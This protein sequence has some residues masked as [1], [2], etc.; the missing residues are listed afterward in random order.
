MILIKSPT[1]SPGSRH[2]VFIKTVTPKN[3][4]YRWQTISKKKPSG[5]SNFN[6]IL[7]YSKNSKALKK[8]INILQKKFITKQWG[9]FINFLHYFNNKTY[10]GL[11]KYANGSYANIALTHGMLPGDII[12]CTNMRISRF[13]RYNLGDTVLL[14]WLNRRHVFYNVFLFHKSKVIFAK[15]AGTFCS[16]VSNDTEKNYAK[17]KLP[18]GDNKVI[19]NQTFVTLGRNSNILQNSVVFGKAG[20]VR[21]N[22]FKSSVRGVAMNPVDHPHGGRTK[23]NS[24]EK[25]PWGKVAKHNK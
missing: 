24:P 17:L 1:S 14:F 15:S 6:G 7:V 20:D 22:G 18:S 23:T 5:R 25:T 12:K 3:N 4:L 11:I 2:K 9:V 8:S 16:M 10:C 13:T 21:K 19:F